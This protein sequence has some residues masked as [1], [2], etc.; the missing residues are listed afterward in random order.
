MSLLVPS[1]VASLTD[2]ELVAR[3]IVEGVRSGPHRSPFR[4]FSTEFDQHRSYRSGDDLRHLDWKLLG[5]TDRLYTRQFR[6]TTN[7]AVMLVVDTSASM[8]F[9]LEG[10]SKLRYATIAAAALAY[11]VVTQGDS[12]GLMSASGEK[13]TYLPA[14]GGRAHLRRVLATLD[15]LCPAETWHP[16]RA[17]ARAA[18]LL[19]RRG[20]IMVLSD[21]YDDEDET[22]RELKRAGRRGHDVAMIQTLSAAELTLSYAGDVE[23]QDLE[24]G[25]TRTVAAGVVRRDYRASIGTFLEDWRGRAR[26]NGI[27]YALMTT[28]DAPER[29]LRTYIVKRGSRLMPARHASQATP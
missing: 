3:L 26:Q 15:A 11:L 5:K 13:L 16:A 20:L 24:S 23:F 22:L 27:D 29:A 8:G 1:V 10:V 9:P 17:I 14:R 2:L 7:M 4:G 12:V 28:D 6:D 25:T 18:D 19:K 21:F